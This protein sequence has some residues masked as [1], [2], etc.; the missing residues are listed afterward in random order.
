MFPT[1]GEAK[2]AVWRDP[3]MLFNII[4]DNIVA[5]KNE[6]ELVL[7]LLNGSIIQLKGADDPNALRGPNPY[8]IVFDEWEKM[9]LE[10]WGDV[11]PIL[12]ANGGWA[13][14]VGTPMGKNHLYNFYQ[15]G[16]REDSDWKS[17]YLKASESGIIPKDQL[18]KA[19]QEMSQALYNQEFECEFLEGEG[20]VFRGVREIMNAVPHQPLENHYYTIGIDLAKVTDYTVISVFDRNTNA[21]VYQDRFKTLEWPFQKKKIKAI[22]DHYNHGLIVIDATGLG[23]PIADDLS[24]AGLAVESYKLT[25]PSKKDLVEKLS[26]YIEQKRIKLLPIEESATEYDNFSYEIG[27]TGRIRY[28]ALTGFHDDIVI[29]HGLG[30]WP[31]NPIFKEKGEKAKNRIQKAY[32]KAK[33]N[34]DEENQE[35]GFVDNTEFDEWAAF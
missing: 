13:W 2:D 31:L 17:F 34:Y 7:Y 20:S 25:E 23:D 16:L 6:Q 21:Q 33:R 30:V 35:G 5:R 26:I 32:E 28:G 27:P 18:D 22:A 15:R 14:F 10:A 3:S 29:S 11:Q 12:R 1:Y 4:P 8:G 19:K 9:K 24:R